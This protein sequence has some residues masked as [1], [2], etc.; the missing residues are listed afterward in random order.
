MQDVVREGMTAGALGLSV[1]REKGHF[2]PQGKLIPAM[3]AMLH[4]TVKTSHR[5][6]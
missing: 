3:P 2:D 5:Y 1:S 6:I 4:V